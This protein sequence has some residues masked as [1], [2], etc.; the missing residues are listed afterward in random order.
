[1]IK[2]PVYQPSLSQLEKD[3]VNDCLDTTWI[4]SKGKY[5]S[6]FEEEFAKFT[7]IKYAAAT[8]NGTT[9]LHLSLLAMGIK[10]GDEVIVPSFTYIASVNAIRYCQATPVFVDSLSSNWQIDPNDIICKIT[11][12]TKAIIPVHLYGHPCDMDSIS[13]IA[14][15]HNLYVI[16]DCAEAF[17]SYYKD[18]HVGS[19]GDVAMFSF[20]GNKTISCGE[21]GMVVTNNKDID[22][23]IRHLKGQGLAKDKEYFH[24]VLGYNYR[25]TNIQ[26]AI[27]LAQLK[28]AKDILSRKRDIAN[29]YQT[30][31]KGTSC[32]FLGEDKDQINSYWMCSLLFADENQRNQVRSNLNLHGVETRPLFPPVHLMPI[33]EGIPGN[34]PVAE[35]LSVRGLNLPSWPDLPKEKIEYICHL[36]KEVLLCKKIPLSAELEDLLAKF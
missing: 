7:N 14:K 28:R 10:K 30:I 5:I 32:L 13:S 22:T 3:Y 12:Q 34:H 36:I 9:A 2:I 31:L 6:L 23:K 21:G 18:K 20:F 35:N 17:G 1:M 4:S 11:P 24:D 19:F 25:M 16:E 27:G 26:A 33:Y 15:E 29:Q 8:C